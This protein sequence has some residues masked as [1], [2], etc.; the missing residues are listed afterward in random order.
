MA[1]KRTQIAETKPATKKEERPLFKLADKD[2]VLRFNKAAADLKDAKAVVD[3]LRVKILAKGTEHF[4]QHNI[5]HP[6]APVKT[7]ELTD[8]TGSTLRLTSQ[9][10][11][12]AA[13]ANAVEALFE[14][15]ASKY[16]DTKID[17]NDYVQETCS[18]SFD[19]SIFN[20][21][22]GRFSDRIYN[23]F[24]EAIE[25]VTKDLI[26]KKVLAAGTPS[27]LKTTKKVVPLSSFDEA[28]YVI[29]PT[30]KDQTSIL[31]VLPNT[32]T[33]TPVETIV[34][35]AKIEEKR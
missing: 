14:N 8:A 4:Y 25:K 22:D 10:K 18:A 35:V 2:I 34:P 3:E 15:F 1:L 5:D 9:A 19:N 20:D 26:A 7:V 17:V 31:E 33:L 23:V 28:R 6:T 24:A 21:A 29:F 12:S 11:Y 27:P 30:V 13:D 32:I 16:P